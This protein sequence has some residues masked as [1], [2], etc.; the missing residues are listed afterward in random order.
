MSR[1]TPVDVALLVASSGL[2]LWITFADV[3]GVLRYRGQF[4]RNPYAL[5]MLGAWLACAAQWDSLAEYYPSLLFVRLSVL[6]IG[7]FVCLPA[8]AL[9]LRAV[10][11]A[12]RATHP[13]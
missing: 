4:L 5:M 2:L 8:C 12:W 13:R 6:A 11:R 10:W 1:G 3:R 7:L 9:S